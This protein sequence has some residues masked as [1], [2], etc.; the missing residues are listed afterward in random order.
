MDAVRAV[1]W[2]V[3]SLAPARRAATQHEASRHVT[4]TRYSLPCTFNLLVLAVPWRP[5]ALYLRPKPASLRV[6]AE[7]ERLLL[8]QVTG[9]CGD[10]RGEQVAAPP[11]SKSPRLPTQRALPLQAPL[12]INARD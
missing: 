8:R 9:G 4:L 12:L 5:S 1:R 6:R 2:R 10:A 11:T 3:R 7:F